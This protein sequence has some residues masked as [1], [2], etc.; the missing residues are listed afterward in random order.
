MLSALAVLIHFWF[1]PFYP[2]SWDVGAIWEVLDVFMAIGIIAAVV[3]TCKHKRGL[4]SDASSL[5]QV[6]AYAA[7]YAAAVLA[8][9]FFW[10]WF[11]DLTTAAGE[12]SQSQTRFIYWPRHQHDVHH[13]HGHCG[14]APVAE[15]G[16]GVRRRVDPSPR[17]RNASPE[18]G[19]GSAMLSLR[20]YQ[21]CSTAKLRWLWQIASTDSEAVF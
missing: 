2:E 10:N 16:R 1:S 6:C 15:V 14:L 12:Q 11:D 13:S 19:V 7:F 8:I 20:W 17:K 21:E 4:P 5:A 18:G 3:Y 9:L